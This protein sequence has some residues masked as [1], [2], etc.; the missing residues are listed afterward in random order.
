MKIAQMWWGGLLSGLIAL[1]AGA[2]APASSNS[3]SFGPTD[4]APAA[5]KTKVLSLSGLDP[6]KEKFQRDAGKIRLVALV[7]PT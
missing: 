3:A 4:P 5:S 1:A 7:S 2:G 6:L